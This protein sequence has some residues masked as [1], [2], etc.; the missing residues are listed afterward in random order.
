MVVC[1]F[2]FRIIPLHTI[3]ECSNKQPAANHNEKVSYCYIVYHRYR[4]YCFRTFTSKRFIWTQQR[5]FTNLAY[6]YV[7]IWRLHKKIRF[8]RKDNR[9]KKL[10]WIFDYGNIDTFKQSFYPFGCKVYLRSI[11][12]RQP[13]DC[14]HINNYHFFRYL[15]ILILFKYK[16]K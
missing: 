12:V 2:I 5:L 4:W 13:S 7:Y 11:N 10:V 6:V 8:K 3:P 16:I 9:I 15:F 1:Y 14:I